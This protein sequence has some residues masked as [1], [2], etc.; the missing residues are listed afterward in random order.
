MNGFRGQFFHWIEPYLSKSLADG[1]RELLEHKHLYQNHIVSFP[2]FD[3]VLKG[4][5]PSFALLLEGSTT[6]PPFDFAKECREIYE[7][8]TELE[9]RIENPFGRKDIGFVAD[10]SQLG[11]PVHSVG[12]TPPTIKSFCHVCQSVEPY[13][14]EHG[15]DLLEEFRGIEQRGTP[16]TEQVFVIAYQCQA[17]KALPEV[18]MVRRHGIKLTLSG[19]T[20]ME[21]VVVP[22]FLPKPQSEFFSDAVVAYNSGQVLAGNFLLRVFIEQ[23]VRS[24]CADPLSQDI[25]ALFTEYG[26]QLPEDFKQRFPSLRHIYNLLSDDIHRA[27]ASEE[28][29]VRSKDDLET[30]F[31][32]KRLFGI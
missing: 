17:C 2:E 20:P 25:D 30:H 31:E 16:I 12:F 1:F 7:S 26:A 8:K 21:Q 5:E 15:I 9:W 27:T 13:N 28:T 32:A 6:S 24:F 4:L 11:K 14:F 29:F 10:P 22:R 3:T 23:Y 18:F 19:R